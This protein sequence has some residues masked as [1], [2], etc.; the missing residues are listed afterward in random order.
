MDINIRKSG[1]T[2]TDVHVNQ[3]LTNISVAFMQSDAGFV[4]RKVFP[5]VPVAKQSDRYYVVVFEG[6]AHDGQ[7]MSEF[8]CERCAGG[9]MEYIEM[10]KRGLKRQEVLRDFGVRG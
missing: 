7:I 8:C 2:Q 6:R 3:P 4:A 10:R 9:G 5:V 1:P